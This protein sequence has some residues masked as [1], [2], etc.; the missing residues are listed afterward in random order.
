VVL[1]DLC[2]LSRLVVATGGGVVLRPLV[3]YD[4]EGEPTEIELTGAA[5]QLRTGSEGGPYTL[6]VLDG[7]G[8]GPAP[9]G[10]PGSDM[11]PTVLILGG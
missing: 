11:H 6:A 4:Q 1:A 8:S 3:R 7:T 5:G 10:S 2:R 9:L